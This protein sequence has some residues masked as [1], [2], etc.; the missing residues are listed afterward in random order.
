VN[1]VIVERF[2]AYVD[3]SAMEKLS[4]DLQVTGVNFIAH[5]R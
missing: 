2:D 1:G 5:K 3:T 4:D